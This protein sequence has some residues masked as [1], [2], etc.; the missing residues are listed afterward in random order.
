M[1]S[2]AT[3]IDLVDIQRFSSVKPAIRE[4]FLARVFTPL[5]LRDCA[6]KDASL[7]G[8]FVAKEAAAKA[9]GCGIGE[10]SWQEIEIQL[11]PQRKPVLHLHG[12]ALDLS[13]KQ[14]WTT[15]SVSIS[16]T[17]ELAIASVTVLLRG[18]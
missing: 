1:T 9:L 7:A 3:G 13:I 4:R 17:S 14:G 2:I 15:W 11:D 5:E 10:I 18:D 12:K 8:R 6:G 16:H